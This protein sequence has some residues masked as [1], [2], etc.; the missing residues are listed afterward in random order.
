MYMKLV[1]FSHEIG[2]IL[3]ILARAVEHFEP[4]HDRVGLNP[5]M[6]GCELVATNSRRAAWRL[7]GRLV[8]K[9]KKKVSRCFRELVGKS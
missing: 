6:I 4:V 3:V 2:C 9:K 7:V 8:G 5:F 1:A